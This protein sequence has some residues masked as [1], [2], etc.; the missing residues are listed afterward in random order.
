M[1]YKE[2][3]T[4]WTGPERINMNA[5]FKELY[6][7]KVTSADVN[8]TPIKP[9]SAPGNEYPEGV[10]VFYDTQDTV[11]GKA[12]IALLS[13][14]LGY[15]FLGGYRILIE[16]VRQNAGTIQWMTIIQTA[17][18]TSEILGTFTRGTY[19]TT[20]I[21][22]TF[23]KKDNQKGI[24]D[25]PS[26]TELYDPTKAKIGR[27]YRYTT[28]E[29][30][31]L[32]AVSCSDFIPVVPNSIYRKN[33]PGHVTFFDKDFKYVY[34]LDVQNVPADIKVTNAAARFVVFSFNT[35]D[36]NKASWKYINGISNIIMAD[37][38]SF[39]IPQLSEVSTS[40]N[41]RNANSKTFLK[42]PT[43]YDDG[44]EWEGRM[45]QATHPSIVQFD[46]E[47]NGYKY[48]MAFT[49]YPFA[50]LST[51]N[52]CVVASN[53]GV[54][55]DIPSGVTNP[56]DVAPTG[57]YNSDTHILFNESTKK[58]EIWYRAV[59][60][61]ASVETLKR[62]TSADGSSWSTPETMLESRGAANI[63]QYIAPSVIFENGKYRMWVMRDYFIYVMES[64][65]GK[66]WSNPVRI[67]AGGDYIHCWHAGVQKYN[68][69]YYL[70]N[71]DKLSNQGSGGELFFYTSEDGINWTKGKK[72][73]TYTGNEWDYDG[74]GVYRSTLLFK[75][76]S[77][78][79]YYGM[80]SN[81]KWTI[82]LSAGRDIDNLMETV[83]YPRR[84]S[85]T[86]RIFCF[87]PN[88]Q[89]CGR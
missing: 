37:E 1:G 12:W 70:L 40:K 22:G 11:T 6:E 19:G 29:Q 5:M 47:W 54:K 87:Y 10:S 65:N 41:I 36:V 16:T 44:A 46:T 7:R 58:L 79:V 84:F 3:G 20:G 77:V 31:M 68:G 34:G 52:P 25:I 21:W 8:V 73:I 82:G 14:T 85:L 62:V 51:E 24:N 35:H 45:H 60:E 86:S 26:G 48:W 17:P 15:D 69:I 32:N 56:L 13:E 76:E 63:L 59:T 9:A 89:K 75:D 71:C 27:Y 39:I 67:N 80:Y 74:Q 53:D 88:Y 2:I 61:N 72:V 42:L 4:N 57:G 55:W 81:K 23:T 28:G 66:S 64:S 33:V 38:R 49:P 78:Y 30:V 50:R 18:A 83:Y 43:P